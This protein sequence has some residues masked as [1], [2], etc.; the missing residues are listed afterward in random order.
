MFNVFLLSFGHIAVVVLAE[1]CTLYPDA[2]GK[3]L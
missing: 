2:T 1:P 3:H